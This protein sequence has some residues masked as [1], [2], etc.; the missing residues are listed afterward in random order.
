MVS[1]R[2]PLHYGTM[3]GYKGMESIR[4]V[5]TLTAHMGAHLRHYDMSTLYA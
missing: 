1:L 4:N 3:R 2:G 5:F